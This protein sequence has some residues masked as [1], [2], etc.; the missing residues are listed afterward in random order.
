MSSPADR[1]GATRLLPGFLLAGVLAGVAAK[2]ADESG[3]RWAADLGTFP[4]A[5]VL[6][7]ALIGRCA[8]TVVA[9]AVRAAVFFASMTLAYY[10][11]AAWVLHF[12]WN[13]LLP[14]WLL[15]SATTVAATAAG[16]RW[17]ARRSGP[18]PAAGWSLA[19]GIV[20]AGGQFLPLWRRVTGTA[21]RGEVL[22][23]P[24]QGVVDAVVALV[25]VLVLP[26]DLP[27]R[28]WALVLLAP[29]TWLALRLFDAF[30]GLIS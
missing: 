24:V 22:I 26:R 29:M 20:L 27:T 19:A 8:P 18:L 1:R 28:I 10:C 6:A 23:H 7:V 3:W 2:A 17:A 5:W 21:A 25:L 16:V 9:A 12:G 30:G 11:Y 14:V 4:A 15:L 13:R